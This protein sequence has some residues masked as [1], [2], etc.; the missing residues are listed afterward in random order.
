MQVAVRGSYN[1]TREVPQYDFDGEKDAPFSICGIGKLIMEGRLT[2]SQLLKKNENGGPKYGVGRTTMRRWNVA[3]LAHDG[4]PH[5]FVEKHVRNRRSLPTSGPP[6]VL[7]AA[8]TALAH[9]VIRRKQAAMPMMAPTVKGILLETAIGLG[10][11]VAATGEKYDETTNVDTMYA[12]FLR[13][14]EKKYDVKLGA[15]KGQ[16]L[17]KQ[18]AVV[19]LS[20]IEKNV[21]I[22]RP[23][24]KSFQDEHGPIQSLEQVGNM[25]ETFADLNKYAT[26]GKLF[27]CPDDNLSNNVLT[28]FERSPHITFLVCVLGGR[29]L[30]LMVVIKG[31][32]GIAP[33]PKHLQLV[34]DRR[35]IGFLPGSEFFSVSNV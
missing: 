28:A 23:A 19:T 5:W 16:A 32:D 9:A 3:D 21:E 24:L 20:V 6:S 17:G 1:A 12:G 2:E 31:A 13:R 29:I 7:G 26:L 33:H 8:E 27:L 30:R 4:K 11:C 15:A 34:K 14:T 25:D 18:R 35:R 10:R 22:V